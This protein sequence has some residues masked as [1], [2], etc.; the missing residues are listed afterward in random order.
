MA[1][2]L[3]PA[4]EQQGRSQRTGAKG[5]AKEIGGTIKEALTIGTKKF[6][7]ALVTPP[8][9][10]AWLYRDIGELPSRKTAEKRATRQTTNPKNAH[11]ERQ[12]YS[13]S[14]RD[15]V[16]SQRQHTARL[17]E[18]RQLPQRRAA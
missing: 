15:R 4:R 17:A 18:L 8:G 6:G 12:M 16:S 5:A 11:Q 10:E 9:Q 2:Q 7:E 13:R 14:E 1:E 3:I